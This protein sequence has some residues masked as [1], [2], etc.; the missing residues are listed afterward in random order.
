[1]VTSLTHRSGTHLNGDVSSLVNGIFFGYVVST[2]LLGITIVQGWIYL[3][4]NRDR[5]TI[6]TFIAVLI[7]LDIAETCCSTQ[8]LHHYLILHFGDFEVLLRFSNVISADFAITGTI[9]F[10]VHLYYARRLVIVGRSWWLPGIIVALTIAMLVVGI[11]TIAVRAQADVFGGLEQKETKILLTMFHVLAVLIDV[12]ITAGLT[13]TFS[14]TQTEFQKTRSILQ[15]LVLYTASRGILITVVQIGHIVMYLVQPTNFLFWLSIHLSL[16][17]LYVIST[18][19]TLNS[20]ASLHND[21]G[22]I[23]VLRFA[24]TKSNS[25]IPSGDDIRGQSVADA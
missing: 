14:T 3:H 2:V 18:L 25:S 11:C 6:R 16:S 12:L 7:I 15:R 21:D 17:K 19:A 1:M 23:E 8:L 4:D 22:V 5:W 10:L 24:H 9:F 13:V 20:R